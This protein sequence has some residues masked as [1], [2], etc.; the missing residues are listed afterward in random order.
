M[1]RSYGVKHLLQATARPITFIDS[2]IPG[3]GLLRDVLLV[4][5]FSLIVVL[6]AQIAIR[7][8]FTP[9]PVTGQTLA[10]LLTG[11]A[12]GAKR[13]AASLGLYAIAG[14]LGLTVFAPSTTSIEGSLIHFILPWEGTAAA[15][16]DLTSGGYIVGFIA[17]AYAVGYL[18]ERGW[19]TGAKVLLA[20]LLANF[21]IYVPG[22]LWLAYKVDSFDKALVYGLYPFIAGDLIKLYL[23][24]VA[25]PGAW[26]LTNKFKRS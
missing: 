2:L 25:L 17:A 18:A 10:V 7:L 4:S 15:L 16:W 5:A 23:A 13:G 26:V 22:L 14:S 12:L 9:V 3:T 8:P 6:F 20:M 24:S 11:G 19:D 21:I 1:G